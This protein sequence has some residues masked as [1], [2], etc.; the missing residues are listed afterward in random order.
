MVS[1]LSHVPSTRTARALSFST[2]CWMCSKRVPHTCDQVCV[3]A[4]PVLVSRRGGGVSC[5]V[6]EFP[7]TTFGG[8]VLRVYKLLQTLPISTCREHVDLFLY[9]TTAK[10]RVSWAFDSKHHNH[11]LRLYNILRKFRKL[12]NSARC[13]QFPIAW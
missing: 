2:T 7:Q 10:K 1:I 6:R 9:I 13:Y 5:P 4:L 11:L 8:G 3:K 12:I